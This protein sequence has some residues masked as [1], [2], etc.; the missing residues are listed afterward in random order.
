M[1][2]SL[3][4]ICFINLIEHEK[5]L[6][7]G[8]IPYDLYGI[9]ESIKDINVMDKDPYIMDF[10]AMC[11]NIIGIMFLHNIGRYCT[12]Y[13]MDH[14]SK[15]GHL[16]V[17]KYLHSIGKD[18][19]RLAGIWASLYGHLEVVKFLHKI[20]K[21]DCRCESNSTHSYVCEFIIDRTIEKGHLNVVKYLYSIGKPFSIYS[22]NLAIKN[23]HVNIVEYLHSIKI[24]SNK[25]P[26]C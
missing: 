19:T 16:H 23:S 14:A 13:A 26:H 21:F 3:K 8:D 15:N 18:C 5:V 17:V 4:N 6:K 10:E 22:M 1:L 12:P 24:C 7:E 11:G 20:D 9:Y 2:I 25:C